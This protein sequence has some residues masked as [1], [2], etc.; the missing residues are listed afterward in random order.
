MVKALSRKPSDV[1]CN[2]SL[3]WSRTPRHVTSVEI[4][5]S[6]PLSEIFWH[7]T[8]DNWCGVPSQINWVLSSFSFSQL[9]FI[10]WRIFSTH[11]TSRCTLLST[12]A[13]AVWKYSWVSSAY[14]CTPRPC[15]TVD[16]GDQKV[17]SQGHRS[18]KLC[19]E[20]W[21]RHQCRSLESSRWRHTASDGN[22][23]SEGGG[24][25]LHIVL[26]APPRLSYMRLA[27]ALVLLFDSYLPLK[28]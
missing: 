2:V 23:A 5:M 12:I 8:S 22:V 7:W 26:I 1:W 17:K 11:T 10:H 16:L 14:E 15:R 24:R 27:D 28:L 6:T 21:R 9:A 13:G 18:P 3:L 20:A 19:L 4:W 25:M